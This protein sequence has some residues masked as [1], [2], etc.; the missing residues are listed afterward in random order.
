MNKSD[1]NKVMI[2]KVTDHTGECTRHLVIGKEEAI[3]AHLIH[4]GLCGLNHEPTVEEEG[5]LERWKWDGVRREI[6]WDKFCCQVAFEKVTIPE[7][8]PYVNQN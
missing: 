2:Y 5:P 6:C 7:R 3:Q 4:Y 8:K 1:N